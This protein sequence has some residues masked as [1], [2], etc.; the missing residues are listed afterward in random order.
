MGRKI[1][2][3]FFSK[4]GVFTGIWLTTVILFTIFIYFQGEDYRS[5]ARRPA[6]SVKEAVGILPDGRKMERY[7]IPYQGRFH[8]VYV[9]GDMVSINKKTINGKTTNIETEVYYTKS[10][11]NTKK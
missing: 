2:D 7:I 3:F 5:V 11:E 10:K 1:I 8:Y 6:L 4:N 9:V